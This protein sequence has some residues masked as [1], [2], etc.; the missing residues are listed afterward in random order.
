MTT[1]RQIRASDQDREN[2]VEL[3]CGAYA[4]GRLRSAEFCQR[5]GRGV[6][7]CDVGR[8]G[9]PDRRSP[10]G[11]GRRRP[12]RG[13][14]GH[15]SPASALPVSLGAAD[16]AGGER[17][18]MNDLRGR[19]GGLHLAPLA[20]LMSP[21]CRSRRDAPERRPPRRDRDGWP[22]TVMYDS[23]EYLARPHRL[24]TSIYIVIRYILIAGEA[25]TA[26]PEGGG[27]HEAI[28]VPGPGHVV[29]RR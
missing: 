3:L 8:A 16:R 20:L 26:I 27:G 9:W 18:R 21:R 22:G 17:G 13:H 2:A 28:H 15:A 7:G 14:C 29:R 1:D 11:T 25:E 24:A 6:R 12:S 23:A 19:V 4:E 5:I 10:P